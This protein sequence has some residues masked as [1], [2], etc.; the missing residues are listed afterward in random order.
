MRTLLFYLIVCCVGFA[1]AQTPAGISSRDNGDGTYTNPII[2]ADY[3]D[4]DV[5]RSGDDYYMTSSSFNCIP[6]LPILHSKDLVNWTIVGHALEA[7]LPEDYYSVPQHGCGVFAPSI[8]FHSGWFFIYWA[9]PDKGIYMVKSQDPAGKWEKP[10]MVKEGKGFIDPCPLWEE[11]GNTAYL[12]HAL[13]G[14]R[15]HQGSMLIMNRLAYDGTHV[16]D[17]QGIVAYDGHGENPTIEGPKLYKCDGWYW[18]FAPAGGVKNGWQLAMRSRNIDGPYEVRRVMERG[19][20]DVNGPHQGGWVTT[21]DGKENWFIHFQDK[22][23]Y[24]RIIHLQPMKWGKDGWP[25]IGEDKDRD[26]IGYPV[27]K[28]KK[29]AVGRTYPPC[30]PQTSDDFTLRSLGKQWQ[31]NANPK[32]YWYYPAGERSNLRLF[33]VYQEGDSVYNNLMDTPNLL[34]QKFPAEEFTAEMKATYTTSPNKYGE[35]AGMVVMGLDYASLT[36]DT[37]PEGLY[38]TLRECKD[39]GKGQPERIVESR[40]LKGSTVWFKVKVLAG[41][42]CR[43]S[44]SE[45]GK[46]FIEIGSTFTA[47][48]GKWIGAKIGVFANRPT[49]KGTCGWLDIDS[50]HVY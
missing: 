16:L 33:T 23:A 26:G 32:I 14:S 28:W 22:G 39:A 36:F 20:T 2:H 21:P 6:G 1:M 30:A 48:V 40:R 17:G 10:V 25:V 13:A 45:N 4:P 35:K 31:W 34:L 7:N 5:C 11:D 50:F 49:P 9:D 27:S 29:P 37:T 19:N 42:E 38:I 41:A 18:I 12:V 43:F 15:I 46:D 24:G 3:S 8:R 47:R 44:Y